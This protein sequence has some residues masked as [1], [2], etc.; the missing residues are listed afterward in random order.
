MEP[1]LQ[2][3]VL[4]ASKSLLVLAQ[5][6]QT[7]NTHEPDIRNTKQLLLSW[8]IIAQSVLARLSYLELQSEQGQWL[9]RGL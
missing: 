5:S 3:E 2:D 9:G 4:L 1:S 8:K 6:L 7:T